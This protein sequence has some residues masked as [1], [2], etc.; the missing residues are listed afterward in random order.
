MSIPDNLP[1]KFRTPPVVEVAC[2][3]LFGSKSE[4]RGAHIGLFWDKI[5]KFFP[6]IQE[7]PPLLPFVESHGLGIPSFDLSYNLS[8]LPPLRRT[9]FASAD[10]RDLIQI[11]QDRFLFNWKKSAHDDVYTSYNDV[12]AKFNSHL[13]GFLVFLAEEKIPAPVYRQF[14]LTYFNQIPI[15]ETRD[16]DFVSETDLLVDHKRDRRAGRF[17]PNPEMVNWTTV[18]ALPDQT[19]R[20]YATAQSAFSPDGRRIVQLEMT[21]RGSPKEPCEANRQGWF[22]IAHEWI[23]R[24]FADLT[25]EKIQ[26][27]VWGRIS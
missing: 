14:E 9:W 7:G 19:G 13:N 10:G 27:S 2:G 21:A 17:L 6:S 4:F 16:G 8:P 22:D 24:G 18:Y 12:M 5:R 3:V 26:K 15:G 11:Q 23:T 20:L 1:V 25:D